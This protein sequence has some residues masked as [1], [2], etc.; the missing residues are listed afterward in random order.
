MAYKK[1]S[2]FSKFSKSSKFS[3]FKNNAKKAFTK[4]Y[5]SETPYISFDERVKK[6]ISK[7]VE[8]KSTTN[9]QNTGYM[10]NYSVGAGSP[11]WYSIGSFN[12]SLFAL[13]QNTGQGNRVGNSIT[14]KKW[15]I[16]FSIHPAVKGEEDLNTS[17]PGSQMGYMTLYMGKRKSNDQM[18]VTLP[19]LLQSGS[20][21]LTPNGTQSQA[22]CALNKDKYHV[23]FQKTFK[24]GPSTI[25]W[26]QVPAGVVSAF[27]T[28]NNDFKLCHR[29]SF[30]VCSRLMKNAKITYNDAVTTAQ[31]AN[32][33]E[34]ACWATWTP[35]VADLAPSVSYSA[36]SYYAISI[37]TY[38]EYEDA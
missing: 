14:L 7:Q 12:T 35:Y 10:C 26:Q 18:Q 15:M 6:V 36:N 34:L 27:I 13:S 8:N 21:S 37:S 28:S 4:S 2:S 32:L 5:K 11:S 25:G 16:N 29:W 3:K 30:D 17:L 9:L 23:Y 19:D 31:N 1:K 20:I 38:A 22:F 33:A 24:C